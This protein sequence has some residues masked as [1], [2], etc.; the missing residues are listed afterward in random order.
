MKCT[1]LL[2][3]IQTAMQKSWFT[4]LHMGKMGKNCNGQPCY[5]TMMNHKKSFDNF[6]HWI[7]KLACIDYLKYV[8]T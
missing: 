8:S 6:A 5:S 2:L 4:Y 1:T 3:E 7:A